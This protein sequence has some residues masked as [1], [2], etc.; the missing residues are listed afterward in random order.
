MRVIR[1][2][3]DWPFYEVQD[4]EKWY[5]ASR[6]FASWYVVNHRGTSIRQGSAIHRRVVAAVAAAGK[7]DDE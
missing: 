4:G 5:T 6:R 2:E 1:L 7:A 3:A